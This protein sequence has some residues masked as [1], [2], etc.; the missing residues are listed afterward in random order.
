MNEWMNE[1]KKNSAAAATWTLKSTGQRAIANVVV[2]FFVSFAKCP[3]N[4]N[5]EHRQR[6]K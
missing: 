2:A 3:T 1:W 6:K 4:V 5:V